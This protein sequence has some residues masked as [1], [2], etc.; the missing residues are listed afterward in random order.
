ML[1]VL[2]YAGAAYLVWMGVRLWPAEPVVPEFQPVSDRRGPSMV[3]ATGVALDLGNPKMPLFYL[4]LLPSVVGATL[5]PAGVAP[6]SAVILAVEVIVIGGHVLLATRARRLL[7][8]PAIVARVNRAPGGVMV[9]AGAAV[10]A[11]R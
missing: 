6:L 9:G 7:R 10:V 11:T 8:S 4:A 5:T 3:F 2:R 1:T